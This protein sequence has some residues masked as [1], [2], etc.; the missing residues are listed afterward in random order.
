MDKSKDESIKG[1]EIDFPHEQENKVAVSR[2]EALLGALFGAGVA[3]AKTSAAAD[4]ACACLAPPDCDSICPNGGSPRGDGTQACDCFDNPKQNVATVATTGSYTDLSNRPSLATVATTGKYSDLLNKPTIPTQKALSSVTTAGTVGQTSNVSVS[5]GNTATVSVPYFTV[6]SYGQITSRGNCTLKVV[7]ATTYYNYTNNCYTNNCCNCGDDSGCFIKGK[8]LTKEG[9]KA[10]EQIEVGDVLVGED[11][12]H[13]ILGIVTRTLGESRFAI[14][15]VSDDSIVLTS[16]HI[17]NKE[18]E[19][20]IYSRENFSPNRTLMKTGSLLGS[21]DFD[22]LFERCKSKPSSFKKVSGFSPVTKTYSFIVDKGLWAKTEGGT[23]VL[24]ARAVNSLT[25][26]ESDSKVIR[27]T[28]EKTVISRRKALLGALFGAGV[29]VAKVASASDSCSCL[30]PPD[31]NSVCANGGAPKGD[32][33]QSCECF[34]NPKQT[35]ATVA[36]TGQYTDL[37]NRPSLATVATTG[38]YSD[39]T[40]RPTIPSAVYPP[41]TTTA[42]SFGPTAAVTIG[43][44]GTGSI[45]IP[46]FTVN[47]YG[48]ITAKGTSTLTVSAG[49]NSVSNC[50]GNYYNNCG[51]DCGCFISG[52]LLTKKGYMAVESIQIG[53]ILIGDDGEHKVLGIATATLGKSRFAISP[54]SD[55]KLVLTADHVIYENGS[56]VI[57]ESKFLPLNRKV[58][59]STTTNGCYDFP[60][61]FS[62]C[63]TITKSF[64]KRT[65]FTPETKTY[66]FIVDSGLWGT[67]EGGTKVLLA[68]KTNSD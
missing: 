42:G 3:I 57:A 52:C 43:I 18:G 7:T 45:A 20:I 67:S 13:T 38:K 10:L 64:V 60:E 2:R 66:T 65:E 53:D 16:E 14:S 63:K 56:P 11:G 25:M 31:C 6:N 50:Y 28:E 48:Q 8:L 23:S 24:L 22:G 47:S 17:I 37:K 9:Y 58:L 33:T 32:G 34:T 68:R 40:G 26:S 35:F 59:T 62:T 12:E 46:Y 51:D 4:A 30:A 19:F 27:N 49:Y 39:L 1:S 36:T 41:T 61:L 15:P 21:Y 44:G 54:V 5:G 29:A 55:D